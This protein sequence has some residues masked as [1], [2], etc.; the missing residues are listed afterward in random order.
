MRN[1]LSWGNVWE[2]GRYMYQKPHPIHEASAFIK[3]R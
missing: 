1:T 3:A 2:V